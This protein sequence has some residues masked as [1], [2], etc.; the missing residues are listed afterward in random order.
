[1]AKESFYFPHDNNAHNDPKLMSLFM[2]FGLAGIGLYW[3]LIEILHQQ[4]DGRI[5][6]NQFE[7]YIRWY[8]SRERGEPISEQMFNK[9]FAFALFSQ[10]DE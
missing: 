4:T 5:T 2:E 9:M 3:I 8:C 6:M 1:M 7:E 10:D